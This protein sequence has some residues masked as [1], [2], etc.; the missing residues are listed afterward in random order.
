MFGIRRRSAHSRQCCPVGWEASKSALNT[1]ATG[2]C[3]HASRAHRG[4]GGHVLA[5]HGVRHIRLGCGAGGMLV[6]RTT[7]GSPSALQCT[8]NLSHVA[9]PAFPLAPALPSVPHPKHHEGAGADGRRQLGHA[10]AQAHVAAVGRGG[11]AWVGWNLQEVT[12]ECS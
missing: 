6:L 4:D 9:M 10:L 3:M 12:C 5:A 11:Q 8:A 7:G 1:I 2:T